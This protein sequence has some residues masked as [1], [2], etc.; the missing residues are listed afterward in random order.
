MGNRIGVMPE[1]RLCEPS[2]PQGLVVGTVESCFDEEERYAKRLWEIDQ[3]LQKLRND[4][5]NGDNVR[6]SL[7][8]QLQT[9]RMHL[10][11]LESRRAR[12]DPANRRMVQQL[13]EIE[14]T[15]REGMRTYLQLEQKI[16]YYRCAKAKLM[17]IAA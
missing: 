1:M 14:R 3:E 16:K 12:R 7:E 9:V 15:I 8:Q 10:A 6:A 4:E 13:R 11:N 5:L 17:G 2:N